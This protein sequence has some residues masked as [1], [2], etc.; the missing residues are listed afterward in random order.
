MR[1]CSLCGNMVLHK[2]GIYMGRN[3]SPNVILELDFTLH[4]I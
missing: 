3:G 1:F 2:P 4:E